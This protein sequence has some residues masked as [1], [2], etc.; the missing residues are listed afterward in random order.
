MYIYIYL[1]IYIYQFLTGSS[2]FKLPPPV[3]HGFH[4]KFKELE[5]ETLQIPFGNHQFLRFHVN[6]SKWAPDPVISRG[7]YLHLIGVVTKKLH[8]CKAI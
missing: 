6:R 7:P 3:V 1:H 8:I 2:V 4:E 5:N